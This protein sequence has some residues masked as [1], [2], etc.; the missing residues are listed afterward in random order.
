YDGR[1]A[2]QFTS[3]FPPGDPA[4]EKP[5]GTC[6]KDALNNRATTYSRVVQNL[7]QMR[8]C[9]AAGYPFV[10]GFTVYSSFE[11]QQVAETGVV[12]M[13]E[14]TEKVMGGHAVLAVGYDDDAKTFIVRNSW[15]AGWGQNGY[16]TMPYAYL[17]TR[18][19][20]SDFSWPSSDS[21]SLAM[22]P[23]GPGAPPATAR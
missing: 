16:F 17:T 3:E 20:S 1:E 5:T 19:L 13:P 10:F 4:A 6:Y 15:A 21:S 23:S 22:L 9:L 14:P 12:P 18:G 7:D 11:S 8:G 2:D